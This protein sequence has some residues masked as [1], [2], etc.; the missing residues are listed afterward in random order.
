MPSPLEKARQAPDGMKAKI[1]TT[2][3]RLFGEYGYHGVTARMIAQAVGIDVS[4]L[5]YHWGEKQDLYEAVLV[6]LNDEIREKLKEIEKAVRGKDLGTRL[7]AAIDVMCD[8]LFANPEAAKLMLLSYFSKTRTDFNFEELLTEHIGNIAVAMGLALDRK[9]VT[10]QANARVLAVW[11]S[12]INFT[13]GEHFLRPMLHLGSPEY[14]SVVKETLRFILIPA[15]VGHR[16][17]M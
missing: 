16:Q 2:A 14:Q 1:L 5:Y 9:A 11:N 3:R 17:H 13:A 4:T 8:Y 6:D 7:A 15:F 12:V 10:P